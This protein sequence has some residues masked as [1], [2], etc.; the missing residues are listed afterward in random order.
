MIDMDILRDEITA[1]EIRCA[2]IE[3]V[4]DFDASP[5]ETDF[6][7]FIE[8]FRTRYHEHDYVL[9]TLDEC[10][11]DIHTMYYHAVHILQLL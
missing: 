5:S 6:K 7:C 3:Y 8:W 9:I 1:K 2:I 10:Y 11:E 4:R